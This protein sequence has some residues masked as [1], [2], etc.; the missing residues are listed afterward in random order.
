LVFRDAKPKRIASYDFL[1]PEPPHEL[2]T[3]DV[4]APRPPFPTVPVPL[5]ELQAFPAAAAA[6]WRF[7]SGDLNTVI[8]L[9]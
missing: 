5:H 2:Q 8:T 4:A 3:D 7:S 6:S 9:S 1:M